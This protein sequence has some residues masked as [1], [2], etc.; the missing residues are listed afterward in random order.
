VTILRARCAFI[1]AAVLS[2]A[3]LCILA[4]LG[5]VCMVWHRDRQARRRAIEDVIRAEARLPWNVPPTNRP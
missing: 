5:V 2:G 4:A 3:T 1:G